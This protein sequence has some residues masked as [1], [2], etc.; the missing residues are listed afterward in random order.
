M[1]TQFH[2]EN[3]RFKIFSEQNNNSKVYLLSFPSFRFRNSH[4]NNINIYS[5]TSNTLNSINKDAV[6]S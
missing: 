5:T 3:G 6:L 4:F 2:C 1:A